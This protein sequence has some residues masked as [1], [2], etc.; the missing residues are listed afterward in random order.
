MYQSQFGLSRRPFSSTPDPTCV[1]PVGGMPEAL[2][3][4]E[5]CAQDG[6]GIGI[7]TAPPGLG[8]TILCRKLAEAL[9]ER[10]AVVF[11]PNANFPTR[12]S[13]LQAV[14]YEMGHPY[15]RLGEQELRLEFTTAVRDLHPDREGLVLIVDEAHLLHQ[16]LLEELRTATHLVHE[17]EMLVRLILCGQLE[18]EERLVRKDLA[19][20]NQRIV[21]HSTLCSLSLAESQE[22]LQQRIEW[23]GGSLES[24]LEPEA[25]RMICQA[26]DGNPRCLNQLC[27]HGLLLASANQE[28]RVTPRHVS[29]ALE[30]LQQLPLHWNHVQTVSSAPVATSH[31]VEIVCDEVEPREEDHNAIE[32]CE[33]IEA[34]ETAYF[35]VGAIEE[36]P[37]AAQET[38]SE[39][40]A[41]SAIEFSEPFGEIEIGWEDEAPLEEG[42][43]SDPQA[44]GSGEALQIEVETEVEPEPQVVDLIDEPEMET[45]AVVD[46]YAQLDDGRVSASAH[47]TRIDWETEDPVEDLRAEEAAFACPPHS[48][49]LPDV[50]VINPLPQAGEEWQPEEVTPANRKPVLVDPS[51][52]IDQVLPMI[53]AV[54]NDELCE[55]NLPTDSK[56][57]TTP[58]C[59]IPLVIEES[60]TCGA[61]DELAKSH[62]Y[63]LS[64]GGED[65]ENDLERQIAQTVLEAYADVQPLIW[66]STTDSEPEHQTESTLPL[67]AG[68]EPIREPGDST[69]FEELRNTLEEA[70]NA[71][72]PLPAEPILEPNEVIEEEP[73]AEIPQREISPPVVHHQYDIVLP[74]TDEEPISKPHRSYQN[75]YSK[76][77]KKQA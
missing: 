15:L 34:P 60:T 31:V 40:E 61:G 25:V 28:P 64:S 13:L 26:S 1:V 68:E 17:G 6:Q 70:A 3:E 50:T 52:L 43:E 11:L 73:P 56:D 29:E 45:E 76:V 9:R 74:E 21:C 39:D 14:L 44:L 19:A 36:T 51:D 77:R 47:R 2:S 37:I 46:H 32:D 18:L 7:L 8:K 23:A 49:E 30:E 71:T 20:I 48:T 53:D 35:E 24:I 66:N 75:L 63:L 42:A 72:T 65:L 38:D 33:E 54:L 27:D 62:E 12:R 69:P 4:L 22:Y 67:V 5:H 10:F 57:D 58:D 16:R 55:S 59:D 41:E